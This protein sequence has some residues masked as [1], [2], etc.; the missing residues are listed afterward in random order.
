MKLRYRGDTLSRI[1]IICDASQHLGL[2][3]LKAQVSYDVDCVLVLKASARWSWHRRERHSKF[4]MESILKKRCHVLVAKKL[5]RSVG[6]RDV[7]DTETL[8]SVCS[9]SVAEVGEMPF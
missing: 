8:R 5:V 9:S 7:L 1:M 2:C 6:L 4:I 3:L